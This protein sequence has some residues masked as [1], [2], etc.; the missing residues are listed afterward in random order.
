MTLKVIG[1]GLGRTGTLSL[2]HALE[3]LGFGPCHHMVEV[4][5]RPDSVPLWVAAGEG[6]ADWD[7]IFDGF[8]AVVDYPGAAFW[9]EIT[10]HYPDAKVIH[11]TRDPNAWFESTQATIF[12][13]EGMTANPPPELAAFF[14]A[15]MRGFA[16]H[17][18]DRD[19]MVDYFNRHT[20]AVLEA[21]PAERLLV[22]E[23]GQGWEPLSAFLEV[24]A[25]DAPY[26]KVNSRDEFAARARD[27]MDARGAAH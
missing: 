1:T 17:R 18:H 9:R 8:S 11:T 13:R 4:F 27:A 14:A 6:H 16:E 19:I 12:T 15:F 2:K 20:E 3:T 24:D 23:A 10:D 21:I 25:P 26:P 5:A 22:Y 7:A